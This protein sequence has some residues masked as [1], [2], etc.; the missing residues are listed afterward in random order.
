MTIQTAVLIETLGRVGGLRSLG[1]VATSFP[2]K[3]HA[4]AA[5]AKAGI[6]VYA[7]EG[8]EQRRVRLVHRADLVLSRRQ[9][10]S[11]LILDDGG[12]LTAMV[13]QKFPELLAGIRGLSEETTTGVHRLYRMHAKRRAQG[14]GHQRQRLGH[15]EQVRQPLWMSRVAGPTAS[16]RATDIMVAGKVVVVGRP[17]AT[18]A[19]AVPTPMK[20]LGARVLVTE[21]DPDQTPCRAALE[22]YEVTTMDEAAAAGQYLRHPRRANRDIITGKHMSVMPQR[23]DRLQTSATFD[24]EI[25]MAL[26]QFA[27]DR[28]EDRDQ[29]AGRPLQPSP[30]GTRS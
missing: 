24:L 16:R 3:D 10:R 22:G 28:Q 17:T 15:Q 2:P 8:N 30:T 6:P 20:S 7:L 4:A 26:A 9:N 14:A 27:E 18:S 29:A 1:A 21:I 19:R 5:I 12:D 25:D 13:H 23:R 11:N